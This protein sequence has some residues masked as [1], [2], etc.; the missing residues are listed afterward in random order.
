MPGTRDNDTR[1][2]FLSSCGAG[3]ASA[4]LPPGASAAEVRS[5]RMGFTP[6]PHLETAQ[7]WNEMAKFIRQN[8]DIVLQHLWGVPW[9]EALHDRPF[10][11]NFMADWKRRKALTAGGLR[12]YLAVTPLSMNRTDISEY[13]NERENMPLPPEFKG[14]AL[15]DPMVKKAYL[16]FCE[17][18]VAYFQPEYAAIGIEVNSL[19]LPSRRQ[20][21]HEYVGLH[22]YVYRELKKRHPSLPVF[23]TLDLHAML[24]P[25]NPDRA[26]MLAA[27]KEIMDSNDVIA[28]SFYPFFRGLSEKVDG[29]L[30]WVTE[31]FDSY[32][33]PYAFAETGEQAGKVVVKAKAAT[34]EFKGSPAGQK[35]YFEK[36]L[37]LAQARRFKFFI[38]WFYRDPQAVERYGWAPWGHCGLLDE[39]GAPR[40]AYA[41]WRKYF[42]MPLRKE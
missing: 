10:H 15:D 18:A 17:R 14:K 13:T 11:P 23:A 24:A 36:A 32:K 28:V 41:V 2:N 19:Y 26:G 29:A 33:K 20:R 25:D 1:R 39:S 4:L 40:P 37:A 3:L 8:G 5:F 22:E 6:S 38:A 21:W 16:N 12:T 27:Y 9:T 42:Q 34:Y 31:T 7:A 30:S 35:A